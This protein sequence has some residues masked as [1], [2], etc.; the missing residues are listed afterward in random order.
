MVSQAGQGKGV[1]NLLIWWLRKIPTQ[2][3][4]SNIHSIR[5][6][7]HFKFNLNQFSF[8]FIWFIIRTELHELARLSQSVSDWLTEWTAS[9]SG[10]HRVSFVSAS[11]D[12]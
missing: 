1:S 6:D 2:A 4:F 3:N 7:D 9:G 8:P 11:K 12:C 10:V 5:S